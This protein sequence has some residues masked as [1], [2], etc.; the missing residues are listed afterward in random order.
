MTASPVAVRIGELSI[1]PSCTYLLQADMVMAIQLAI[2]GYVDFNSR[3][4]A[5]CP[6]ATCRQSTAS[7]IVIH[8]VPCAYPELN[9]SSVSMSSNVTEPSSP[10]ARRLPEFGPG[11]NIRMERPRMELGCE[12]F[13]WR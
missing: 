10:S 4:E 11:A 6:P 1:S 5:E 3:C 13:D 2:T 7:G 12:Q 8:L 9:L